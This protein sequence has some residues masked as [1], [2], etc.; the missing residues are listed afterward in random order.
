MK[1]ILLPHLKALTNVAHIPGQLI[2]VIQSFTS[3]SSTTQSVYSNS[4]SY[5]NQLITSN[6][7]AFPSS[8]ILTLQDDLEVM[9][10]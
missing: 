2:H 3:L 4:V 9:L 7:T 6:T 1:V 5:L 10:E 8:F